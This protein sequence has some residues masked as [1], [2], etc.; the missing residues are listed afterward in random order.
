[1]TPGRMNLGRTNRHETLRLAVL[2]GT[3]DATI[4]FEALCG[5]LHYL[6]FEVRIRGSHHVE[7]TTYSFT[8]AFQSTS[9]SR[10]TAKR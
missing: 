2:S 8:R 3:S 5:L 7:A 9:C 6:S 10:A 4:D 1:M